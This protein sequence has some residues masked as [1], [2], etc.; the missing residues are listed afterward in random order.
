MAALVEATILCSHVGINGS[1]ALIYFSTILLFLAVVRLKDFVVGLTNTP[2]SR[3]F[4]PVWGSYPICASYTGVPPATPGS[5]VVLRCDP[6]IPPGRY[7]VVQL[8]GEEYQDICELEVYL[9][10]ELSIGRI[11]LKACCWT[12]HL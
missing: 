2:P 6:A 4:P 11:A 9:S 12:K 7:V 1:W 5:S 8:P 10:G 3:E